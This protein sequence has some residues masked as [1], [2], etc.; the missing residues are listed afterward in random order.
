MSLSL[1]RYPQRN[2]LDFKL[3][4]QKS[5]LYRSHNRWQLNELINYYIVNLWT[6]QKKRR[7]PYKFSF[8]CKS[9]LKLLP[10]GG[11]MQCLY[12]RCTNIWYNHRCYQ[13]IT[14]RK[15]VSKLNLT[16]LV[17]SLQHRQQPLQPHKKRAVSLFL[18]EYNEPNVA[19]SL[20]ACIDLNWQNQRSS[21]VKDIEFTNIVQAPFFCSAHWCKGKGCLFYA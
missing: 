12:S 2:L 7:P 5:W 19:S 15:P 10:V 6:L 9:N 17:M 4:G 21:W 8:H 20:W 16:P 13:S 3:A 18:E 11:D 1:R 14:A